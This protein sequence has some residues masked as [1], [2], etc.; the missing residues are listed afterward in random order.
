MHEWPLGANLAE[1]E[2]MAAARAKGVRTMIGLQANGDPVLLR[3][4]EL[5]A[6]GYVGE[7]LSCTMAMFLPGLLQRGR[8]R[9]WMADR[10]MGANTLSIATGHAID[11]LCFCVADFKEV[12][13]LSTT[14][15]PVWETAEPG[16]TVDVTAPDNVLVSG[17]LTNGAVASV[18]IA[19]VPWHGTGWRLEVYGREGTL[20]AASEQMVQYAEIRLQGGRGED[21]ALE[22]L[23]VPDR[24]TWVSSAPGATLQCGPDVPPPG[25]GHPGAAGGASRLRSGSQAAPPPGRHAAL[26][27]PRVA[28]ARIVKEQPRRRQY[29]TAFPGGHA[30]AH[31]RADLH[32]AWTPGWLS[33]GL[34]RSTSLLSRMESHSSLCKM[35]TVRESPKTP[36]HTEG[37]GCDIEE[38]PTQAIAMLQRLGRVSYRALK[39]QFALDDAFLEDLEVRAHR[40]PAA[41]RRPRRHRAGLDRG[42]QHRSSAHASPSDV[43][44]RAS[45]SHE[46]D[47]RTARLHA[48]LSR[49]EDFNVPQ[50]AG[51]RTQAG[52]GAVCRSQR[53]HGTPG[54][55][56]PGGG[57][58]APRPG[59]GAHDGG[60]ASL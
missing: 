44:C 46:T 7:V 40:G 23:P 12:A 47:T 19:T 34:Q 37:G 3:L 20:V 2:A 10:A 16:K 26:V 41:R 15:V 18:H 55:P 5:L 36:R 21:R 43:R 22:A 6:E 28:S 51:R 38:G 35:A 33:P 49:G 4:R 9:A 59:A 50:C 31:G 25:R 29:P 56:R 48:S 54:G 13:A 24:L 52:H 32:D 17:V 60:R 11:V 45:P 57:P 30:G 1:A 58:A 27:R 39:R 8:D 14:Q 53:L 42:R